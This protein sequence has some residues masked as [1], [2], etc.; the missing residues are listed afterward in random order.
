MRRKR[1]YGRGFSIF[2]T[3]KLDYDLV[4]DWKLP[5][6]S[7]SVAL[8]QSGLERWVVGVRDEFLLDADGCEMLAPASTSAC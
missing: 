4:H 3:P 6:V 2:Q 5:Y 1:G 8:V 7:P